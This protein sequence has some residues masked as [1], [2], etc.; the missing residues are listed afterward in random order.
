MIVAA[1]EDPAG[2]TWI[3][4]RKSASAF[5]ASTAVH[6]A[7]GDAVDAL[8]LVHAAQNASRRT[9]TEWDERVSSCAGIEGWFFD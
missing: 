9:A 2:V 1:Q 4:T 6:D 7:E 8:V 3:A 5:T